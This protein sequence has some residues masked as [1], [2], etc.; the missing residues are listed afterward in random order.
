M[1]FFDQDMEKTKW[2]NAA[3]GMWYIQDNADFMA[4]LQKLDLDKDDNTNDCALHNDYK[5]PDAVDGK[6]LPEHFNVNDRTCHRFSVLSW[7]FD[8]RDAGACRYAWEDY[9]L[10]YLGAYKT[11]EE[12]SE[13]DK[14]VHHTKVPDPQYK[15]FQN[16]WFQLV[17]FLE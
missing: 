17:M 2:A 15:Y 3:D 10:E 8:C 11:S 4:M 1:H 5:L 9:V 7:L 14:S 12:S 13:F 16:P 6:R